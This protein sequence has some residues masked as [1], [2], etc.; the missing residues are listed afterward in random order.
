MDLSVGFKAEIYEV[1]KEALYATT[2]NKFVE[3][4]EYLCALVVWSLGAYFDTHCFSPRWVKSW[5]IKERQQLC[6]LGNNTTNR[7]KSS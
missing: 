6:T 7:I 3:A 2:D 4:Q 5:P 1:F